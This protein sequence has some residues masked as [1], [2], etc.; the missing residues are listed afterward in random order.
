MTLAEMRVAE[1]ET[2]AEELA[3]TQDLTEIQSKAGE[4]AQKIADMV[5]DE[6]ERISQLNADREV[7]LLEMFSAVPRGK[8]QRVTQ[9]RYDA[10]RAD[11]LAAKGKITARELG[12]K[13]IMSYDTVMKF[14]KGTYKFL[15]RK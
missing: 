6:R 1:L 15:G 12:K 14:L 9:E 11:F 13:H 3:T 10:V 7:D 2:A 5:G 4:L 8:K